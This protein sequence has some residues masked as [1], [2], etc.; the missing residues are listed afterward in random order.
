MAN[1]TKTSVEPHSEQVE[2]LENEVKALRQQLQNAQRLA[3]IGTMTAMVAH[4]FNNILTPIISYARLAKVN[5]KLVEKANNA[6]STEDPSY[7]ELQRQ[8]KAVVEANQSKDIFFPIFLHSILSPISPMSS[9][10]AW[11]PIFLQNRE[12][13]ITTKT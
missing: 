13:F 8:L 2:R 7:L 11:K 9:S 12:L 6:Q 10:L 1:A 3:S 4:E 5:P